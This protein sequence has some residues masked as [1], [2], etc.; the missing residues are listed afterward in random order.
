M[1]VRISK[2]KMACLYKTEPLLA[3][4]SS[5]WDR[6]LSVGSQEPE[7]EIFRKLERTARPIG[8]DAFSNLRKKQP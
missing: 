3:M 4:I 1:L 7:M 5:P 6:F 2:A 8:N